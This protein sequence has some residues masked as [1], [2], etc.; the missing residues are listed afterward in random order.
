MKKRYV[1]VFIGMYFAMAAFSQIAYGIGQITKPINIVNALRGQ[2]IESTLTL[3]NTGDQ[4]GIYKL[5]AGGEIKD[6]TTFYSIDDESKAISEIKIP[7]NT[8]IKAIAKFQIPQDA[9]NKK[10]SGEVA[11]L[12]VP[13]D[14]GEGKVSVSVGSRVGRPVSIT[15]TD[16]EIIKMNTSIIPNKYDLKSGEP[17][18]IRV[19]YDNRGN[20]R[21]SP[22]LQVKILKDGK[23]FHNAIYPFPENMEAINS[24]SMKEITSVE[25]Q[26]AGFEDGKYLAAITVIIDENNKYDKEFSFRIRASGPFD[27]FG[28]LTAINDIGGRNIAF[29]LILL[30]ALIL[31]V[32]I[33]RSK[34]DLDRNGKQLNEEEI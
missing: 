10:Y 13:K 34:K 5:E 12:E 1:A 16:D 32:A 7:P 6:W 30:G 14:I 18:R 22:Q 24:M 25:I 9:Q 26:T 21:I 8:N 23:T 27:Y 15:V 28:F 33:L 19:I 20:T 3:Y 17:L 29:A 4:E 2:T 11:I 31:S